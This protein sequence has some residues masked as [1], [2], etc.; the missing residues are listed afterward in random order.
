MYKS[1]KKRGTSL[2]V[3]PSRHTAAS[4]Q[5]NLANPRI[6]A[7]CG[8]GYVGIYYY[9]PETVNGTSSLTVSGNAVV[10]T[11]NSRI[12]GTGFQVGVGGD[13][14]GGIV[15]NGKNGTVYGD[16]I[17]QDNLTID[18]D[19]TLTVPEGFA[20]NTNG[21]L[22]NEG[23]INVESGG[24]LEGTTTG[25]G[26]LKIAPTITTQPQDVELKK[27]ETATFAVKVTGTESLSYR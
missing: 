25:Q 6:V 15:F 14:N 8:D 9:W 20:L 27:N 16:V 10:D 7:A 21:N 23:T 18:K 26:T 17:L 13:G 11:R 4:S 12:M 19:E 5:R 22:T 2:V 24:K 3:L 1:T